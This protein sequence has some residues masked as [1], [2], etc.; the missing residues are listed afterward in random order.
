MQWLPTTDNTVNCKY[1]CLLSSRYH[2]LWLLFTSTNFLLL[3]CW[4]RCKEE[5]VLIPIFWCILYVICLNCMSTYPLQCLHRG[6]SLVT[7]T[8][9]K[10]LN[11]FK[12]KIQICT[13][14]SVKI[15]NYWKLSVSVADKNLLIFQ[16]RT[17]DH[18]TF[19]RM[20]I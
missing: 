11:L 5:S 18:D 12:K 4:T 8:H 15:D 10:S 17:R 2:Q 13:E 16:F 14:V 1:L 6:I 3:N 19:A 20:N 7:V 9:F